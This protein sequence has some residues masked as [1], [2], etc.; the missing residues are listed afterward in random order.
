[1]S[2]VD[3]TATSRKRRKK[4]APEF[5]L[6]WNFER[7]R[8]REDKFN[9]REKFSSDI[10]GR[11]SGISV[12]KVD[13]RKIRARSDARRSHDDGGASARSVR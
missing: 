10:Y 12:L 8:A 6:K 13:Y 1:M 3:V 7:A 4:S 11:I 9:F 5:T 2:L